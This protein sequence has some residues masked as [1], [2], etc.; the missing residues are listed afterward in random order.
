MSEEVVDPEIPEEPGLKEHPV[1]ETEIDSRFPEEWKK[2][3]E[4]LAYLG[5][6]TATVKIPFHTFTLKTLLP[7]EKIEIG[8]ICRELEGTLAYAKSFKSAVVAASLLT[9]DGQ[10]VIVSEKT[11]GFVLQKYEYIINTWHEP[12]IDLL[13]NTVNVLEGKVISVL[14]EMGV[15]GVGGNIVTFDRGKND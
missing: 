5:Y 14:Q 9:V 3:F 6:L 7:T 10:P 4:G 1:V 13:Y 12:I 8:L 11:R 2:E 15:L